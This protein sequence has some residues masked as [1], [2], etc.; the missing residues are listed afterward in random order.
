MLHLFPYGTVPDGMNGERKVTRSVERANQR[1][2]RYLAT[3]LDEL[4]ITEIEAHLLARLSGKGRCS[5]ADLQKAFG[6]RPSTLTNA[7]DRLERRQLVHREPD[8]T[9]RRTFQ[10]ALTASGRKAARAVITMV[11][12]LEARM[13]QRVTAAELEAFHVVIAALEES[14]RDRTTDS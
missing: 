3:H 6:L 12:A 2:R 14:C 8:P 7:L 9:D 4:D 10:L 13:A 1:V 11:D 5:V